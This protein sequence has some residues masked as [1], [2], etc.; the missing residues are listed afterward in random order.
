MHA[1]IF[2]P[3]VSIAWIVL[4]SRFVGVIEKPLWI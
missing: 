4:D 2:K 1:W 3:R